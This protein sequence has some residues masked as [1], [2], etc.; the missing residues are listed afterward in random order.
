MKIAKEQQKR[1][2][3][4]QIII[5]IAVFLVPAFA[6][7]RDAG[8]SAF[9]WEQD[10]LILNYPDKSTCEML[11][12]DVT[13]IEY[14]EAFDFGTPVTGGTESKCKYGL[15]NNEELGD[16]QICC[17]VDIQSCI[18]FTTEDTHFV[19]SFESP[20]TTLELYESVRNTLIETGYLTE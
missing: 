1:G 9:R 16:Y 20:E 5:L 11:F 8:A 3:K 19:I 17:H 10:R 15:W 14:R 2:F 13:A 6:I 12:A 7:F 18:I 4:L